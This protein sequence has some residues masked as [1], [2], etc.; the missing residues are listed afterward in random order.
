MGC[1]QLLL[2]AKAYLEERD[3]CG[4]TALMWAAINGHSDCVDLLVSAK[5]DLDA[6]DVDE[7]AL[8]WA[9]ALG[10]TECVRLL[11]AA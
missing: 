1:F 5:A 8:I 9:T 10:E 11:V 4:I 6:Q 3:N 2:D 7:T